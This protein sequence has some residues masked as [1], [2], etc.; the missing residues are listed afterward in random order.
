[1]K[2]KIITIDKKK[3][4]GCGL[5]IPNCP[6]G[7]LQIIDGKAR[8]ISDLFCDGLGACIGTC[9]EG[10]ITIEERE[11]EPYDEWKVMDNVI[12]GGTNVI[13]AHLKHLKDH[14][15]Q[16]FYD[17]AIE[18][19]TEKGITMPEDTPGKTIIIP[20]SDG[21]P[22]MKM[23]FKQKEAGG[24][25][26]TQTKDRTDEKDDLKERK[27][28]KRPSALRQWPVQLH[29][30][31]PRAPY[32]NNADLLVAADCV[33]FTLNGFHEQYL[34]G[35]TLVIFCPKLDDSYEQYVEKL[36]EI[37]AGNA[38]KSIAVV[39]ME[40]PCCGGTSAIVDA[41]LQK[42]GKDIP[43]KEVIVSLTGEVIT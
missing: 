5:C 2:R 32:F 33:A 31:N 18:Y 10:A 14:G 21:C 37:L 8:L 20:P 40:V 17:Q 3:C 22:G 27:P 42:S 15:Q 26:G 35:K 7:A 16:E 41:A 13:K 39:R 9:P 19:L 43:R 34:E 38:V 11:A 24:C 6:E 1:M 30:L 29:L 36:T 12:E 28:G 23:L 4:N 25:P